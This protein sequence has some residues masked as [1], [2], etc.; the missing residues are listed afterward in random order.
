MP[1]PMNRSLPRA[2]P[3]L[4]ALEDRSVPS[5]L[6]GVAYNDANNNGSPDAGEAVLSSVK[7]TLTGTDS[8]NHS[9][10]LTATTGADGTY[11]FAN[12]EP[13]TYSVR[14]AAAS[15]YVSG[16]ASAGSAGGTGGFGSISG[17]SLGFSDATGNDFGQLARAAGWSAIASNFNGNSIQAGDTLWF[18]SVF[19][20]SNLGSGTVTLHVT[21]QTV[22]FSAG[23]TNYVVPVPDSTIVLSP[24]ATTASTTFD[25]SS[26]S[27]V[28]TLPKSFSGNAFLG[29]V[30]LPLGV[31]LPGGINP[32]VWQGQFT[33]DTP[34]VSINWQWAAAVYSYFGSDP[35]TFEVK[36]VDDNHLSQYQ[37]SDHAGTPETFASFVLGGARGGGGSNFTGSYSATTT[38]TPGGQPQSQLGTLR[39]NIGVY[40]DDGSFVGPAVNVTLYLYDSSGNL[41]GQTMTDGQ[42]NYKFIDLAAG[43]YTIATTA[44]S[45]SAGTVNGT[46]PDGQG[47]VGFDTISGISL[48]AGQNGVNYDFI[49]IIHPG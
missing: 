5:T 44:D 1:N 15:G 42:G 20:A 34:G 32:V 4:E 25:S 49:Q 47:G 13:G 24:T 26:N 11:S 29:G 10:N 16:L 48:G 38:V 28:T 2:T 36:P 46:T 43:T 23:G 12:L 31:T 21:G 3:T 27:W 6:S 40:L 8:Q 41:V 7:V 39:G 37:N 14:A 45:S 19:K 17:I 22:R 33:S 35:T 18:S 9:V 30:A